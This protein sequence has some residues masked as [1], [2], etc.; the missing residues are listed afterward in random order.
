[1]IPKD[2]AM[3]LSWVNTKLRDQYTSLDELCSAESLE[4]ASLEE[5]LAAIDYAYDP[6]TNRF[7]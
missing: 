4:K 5:A 1:M 7:V 3:L 6:D 2:P